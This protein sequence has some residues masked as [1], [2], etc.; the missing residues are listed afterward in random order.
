MMQL[1]FVHFRCSIY[2]DVATTM[3]H[4]SSSGNG[5]SPV[6]TSSRRCTSSMAAESPSLHD[7]AMHASHHDE[8]QEESIATRIQKLETLLDADVCA[9]SSQADGKAYCWFLQAIF[10]LLTVAYN[11]L[12]SITL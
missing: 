8:D 6:A 3:S 9:A 12:L 10:D 5:K 1:S 7:R 2:R 11:L 4:K